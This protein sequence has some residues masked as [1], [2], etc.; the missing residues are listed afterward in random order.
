[1]NDTE[2]NKGIDIPGEATP[3]SK[4]EHSAG[5]RQYTD[6]ERQ[7]LAQGW[8]PEDQYEGTKKWRTAEEFLDRGEL[9]AKI[10][11][12]TRKNKQLEATMY[13]LKKHL[14]NVRETEFKR[15]LDQLRQEKREA[16]AD[17]DA[18]KLIEIDEKIADTKAAQVQEVARIEATPQVVPPNPAFQV[19]VNRNQWYTENR[20]MK[21]AADA[22]GDDLV[23]QGIKDPV[24]ILQEVER[25]IKKEF[26]HQFKNPNRDKPGAVE[27]GGTGRSGKS[28]DS[29]QLT[30]DEVRAMNKFVKAGVLT[31][32]EYI[33]DIKAQR[34]A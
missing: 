17:G 12:A 33:A 27:G 14:K 30:D 4:E 11:D 15:A 23:A 25:R 10:D 5:D 8:V 31:K 20:L 6:V 21:A 18:D 7:A 24:Q 3:E 29:F 28:S 16:L 22:V 13:E 2:Q 32:E 9:F 34:G 1:M 26:P 19:W